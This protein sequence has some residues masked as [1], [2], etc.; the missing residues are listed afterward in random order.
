LAG[1]AGRELGYADFSAFQ[2]EAT[3]ELSISGF[4]DASTT[5][6]GRSILPQL[7]D[8]AWNATR[9]N[10]L[11]LDNMA[12]LV[13]GNLPSDAPRDLWATSSSP[14][15][16][17]LMS[18]NDAWLDDYSV[19]VE[20]ILQQNYGFSFNLQ[21]DYNRSSVDSGLQGEPQLGHDSPSLQ[22]VFRMLYGK[23]STNRLVA[24][25]V[26][27]TLQHDEGSLPDIQEDIV[28]RTLAGHARAYSMANGGRL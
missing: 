13:S 2:P 12:N 4:Q 3:D 14:G 10:G 17:R 22:S 26:Q 27:D 24:P 23:A 1:Q 21:D 15:S 19:C 6:E 25:D 16:Q 5:N 7:P 28:T 9:D 20:D 8:H 11:S 18:E